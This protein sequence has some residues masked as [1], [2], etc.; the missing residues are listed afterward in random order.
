MTQLGLLIVILC[1]LGLLAVAALLPVRPKIPYPTSPTPP[2][3]R[4]R[5]PF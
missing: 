2:E 4:K 5:R 3:S 1:C